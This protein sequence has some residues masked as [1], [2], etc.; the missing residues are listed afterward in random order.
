MVPLGRLARGG[1]L[2]ETGK[3]AGRAPAIE[4]ARDNHAATRVDGWFP[5]VSLHGGLMRRPAAAVKCSSRG[6]SY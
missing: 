1:S 6:A 2:S 3:E 5:G 4:L